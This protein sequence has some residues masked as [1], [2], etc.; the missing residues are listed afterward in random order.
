MTT[1]LSRYGPWAIVAGASEGLGAAYAHYLANQGF[2]LILMARRETLLETLALDLSKTY[3]IETKVKSIDLQQAD[4]L[5]SYLQG[6][7]P[8]IGLA[9]YNAAY[10]P[11]GYFAE[12]SLDDLQMVTDVNVKSPLL[13]TKVIVDQYKDRNRTGGIV[14]MS[15]L[16]GNQGSPRLATYA[17]S[18]S[19]NTVLAEGLWD[20]LREDDIDIIASIAGAIRTPGYAATSM[21]KEAPG[22]LEPKQVVEKTIGHLGKGPTVV[23]GRI[24]SF[25]KFVMTRLLPKKVAI[26]IMHKNTKSLR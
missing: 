26:K 6:D 7:L 18:K 9:I 13:F 11:L 3:G 15:S 1:L 4:D 25:G 24:N 20:E 10:A 19:F 16:A 8:D 5:Y 21:A 14:L 23:P 22:T 12:L 2:H 17:A